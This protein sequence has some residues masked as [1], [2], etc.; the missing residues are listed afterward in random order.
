MASTARPMLLATNSKKSYLSIDGIR[1]QDSHAGI[2]P[3]VGTEA[4]PGVDVGGM[5]W[6]RR[7]FPNGWQKGSSIYLNISYSRQK[8][9]FG[10][11]GHR[12]MV[13]MHRKVCRS[14]GCC[15][16]PRA[17]PSVY[18]PGLT[19]SSSM[20]SD[21]RVKTKTLSQEC[22]TDQVSAREAKRVMEVGV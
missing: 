6:R 18:Q 20:L 10:M 22:C 7:R 2:S 17:R 16:H 13:D 21:S 14:A 8:E 12:D 3:C 4:P 9:V 11:P 1:P 19:C 15:L 5:Q